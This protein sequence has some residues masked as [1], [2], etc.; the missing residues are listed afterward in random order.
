MIVTRTVGIS[1]VLSVVRKPGGG[2]KLE[3]WSSASEQV[4]NDFESGDARCDVQAS[5]SS[6]YA[7]SSAWPIIYR[8]KN[9]CGGLV[10]YLREDRL[11][12]PS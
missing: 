9:L 10:Y 1:Q 6:Q 7:A 4:D 11:F 12:L 8:T 2:G 5:S 3:A